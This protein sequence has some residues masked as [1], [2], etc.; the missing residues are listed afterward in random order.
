VSGVEG[1]W[2]QYPGAPGGEAAFQL[3]RVE[4]GRIV[5]LGAICDLRPRG[6]DP[7]DQNFEVSEFVS[8]EDG[9][10]VLLHEGGR[11]FVMGVRS[12]GRW[13]PPDVRWGLTLEQLTADV[14]VV[15]LPDDENDPEPHP[16]SWL[17]DLAQC[18]GLDVTADELRALPYDV[19]FTDELR[20]WLAAYREEP[21]RRG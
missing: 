5:G 11:G 19:V 21:P 20:R 15:V 9:R 18:R 10:R 16:W 2:Q 1:G 7:R 17:A 14:L 12:T 13:K 8:L 4:P 6:A 3:P